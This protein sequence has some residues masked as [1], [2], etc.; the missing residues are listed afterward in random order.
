MDYSDIKRRIESLQG[1]LSELAEEN[2][3]YLSMKSHSREDQARHRL[4]QDRVRLGRA[5]LS[6]FVSLDSE[7]A[8]V[9]R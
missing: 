7:L 3:K 9:R 5:E 4:L 8:Q 6:L 1:E 2:R